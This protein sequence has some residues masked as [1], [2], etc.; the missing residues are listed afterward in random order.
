MKPFYIP[1]SNPDG[2][3][4]NVR[5]LDTPIPK[6]TVEPFDGRKWEQNAQTL[7]HLSEE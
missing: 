4:I 3:D 1:R 6:L 7:K 2:I 5:C